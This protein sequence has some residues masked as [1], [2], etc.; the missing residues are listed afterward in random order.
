MPLEDN[1]AVNLERLPISCKT[2]SH[3]SPLWA[4]SHKVLSTF[5]YAHLSGYFFR[6]ALSYICTLGRLRRPLRPCLLLLR[7]NLAFPR[8]RSSLQSFNPAV[9]SSHVSYPAF[10]LLHMLVVFVFSCMRIL[11]PS[12]PQR[13]G[14]MKAGTDAAGQ[15]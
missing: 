9:S 7:A 2:C 13:V 14:W 10:R 6:H 4:A 1:P 15:S 3:P 5:E 8:F 12:A 11:L